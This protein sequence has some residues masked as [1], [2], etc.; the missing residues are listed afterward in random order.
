MSWFRNVLFR[1]GRTS[2]VRRIRRLVGQ[3]GAPGLN[4]QFEAIRLENAQL[5]DRI[6]AV[7]STLS[8]VQ[9]HM[10]AVLSAIQS[11]NGTTRLLRRELDEQVERLRASV[12]R[13]SE[14]LHAAD[15]ARNEPGR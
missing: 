13:L 9:R 5:R 11:T 1:V 8:D 3:V 14:E 12:E 10:P 2:A 7:A 4:P 15:S 6:D